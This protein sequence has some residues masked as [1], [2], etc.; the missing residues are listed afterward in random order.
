MEALECIYSRRSVRRFTDQHVE[1][2][3]IGSILEAGRT[4]PSAGNIQNW[5]FIVVLD[6]DKRNKIS[7]VCLQQYWMANA[8]IHIIICSEPEKGKRFYGVRGERLYAV[9]NCAAAAENMMLAANSL[10]LGSCWVGAF[11]EDALKT[12]LGI[13]E[14]VRPQIVLAIG[15]PDERPLMPMRYKLEN[16]VHL[17]KYGSKIKDE[18]MVMGLHYDK[19]QRG[20][21]KA[22]DILDKVNQK[23]R[24]K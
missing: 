12:E 23:L 22:K 17:E 14:E 7:E 21:G 2:D 9:Q 8:P 3:K 10:G 15:Y 19:V 5:K 18:A 6:K 16:I 11:D 13:I 24:K 20:I 1:W 4:A